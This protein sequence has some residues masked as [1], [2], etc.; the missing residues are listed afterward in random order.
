MICKKLWMPALFLLC[1][2]AGEAGAQD[3]LK[4][5]GTFKDVD[6]VALNLH[7]AGVGDT[8]EAVRLD[9][10]GST[11]EGEVGKSASG[12]YQLYGNNKGAQLVVPLYLPDD[13]SACKLRLRMNDGCTVVDAG[14]DN[15]A[16]SAFNA[17]IYAKGSRFWEKGKDMDDEALAGFLKGYSQAA[18]SLIRCYGCSKPVEEY[19][20]LW[21]Y[22]TAY[23]DYLSLARIARRR[24]GWKPFPVSDIL[25][26]AE[27]VLD[28]PKSSYFHATPSIVFSTLPKGTLTDRL[29][30]LYGHYSDPTLLGKVEKLVTGDYV[31]RFRYNDGDFDAGLAELEAAVAKFG[32]DGSC[33]DRFKAR[34]SSIKGKAFPTGI[35]LTDAEGNKM[36]F[37]VFKGYYVYV[38]LWASWCVPC[39]KEVPHLQKLEKELENK[40]VRFLSISLDKDEKAWKNRMASLEMYGYQ[41]RDTDDK[42]SESLN[43][44]G[45]PHFLIYDKEGRLY[46]G[47]A[48]RPSAPET[49]VLLESL[50]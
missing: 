50:K 1:G 47:D 31:R 25:E 19:L 36:D 45:I 21:S 37:G 29:S 26:D 39:C 23:N 6:V 3:V 34:K 17:L 20:R 33:V 40:N 22:V 11:F 8:A 12:F 9:A 7:V 48:P 4:L 38:D 32:L 46:N 5:K 42:L 41:W 18:D 44:R 16:L 15:L 30:Y 2:V 13:K 28:G 10:A 27:S 14:K 43:V 24:P 35:E 49:R